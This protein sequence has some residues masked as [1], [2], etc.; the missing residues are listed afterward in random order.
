MASTAEN[1]PGAIRHRAGVTAA[2]GT[3]GSQFA[4]MLAAVFMVAMGYGVI[5]PVLP[6]F[7][8]R[9]QTAPGS[10]SVAW[11][12]GLLTGIYMF[13]LFVFAPLWGRVSDR[14]GRRPVILI[15]FA[16]F[17][18]TMMLFAVADTLWLV[19]PSRA[20]SGVFS[21]AV[22]PVSLAF[23]GDRTGPEQ[24]ARGFALLSA[25]NALGFLAGPML[26]GG[27]ASMNLMVPPIIAA[28]PAGL[29]AV[30]LIAVA[31]LSAWVWVG[32]Y[33]G[34]PEPLA[35]PPRSAGTIAQ[36]AQSQA[37]ANLLLLTLLVMFGLGSFE[38][39]IALHGQQVLN[40]GAT[41]IGF[42]FAEC[43]LVMIAVQAVIF[44]PL[45]KRFNGWSL[46]GPLFLIMAVGLALFPYMEGFYLLTMTVGLVAASSGI[47]IPGLTYLLSSVAGAAQGFALGRQTAASS[48]GQ[49]LGSTATGLL[50]VLSTQSP[51]W[52]ATG[53]LLLAAIVSAHRF[54]GG[55]HPVSTE[56][57]RSSWNG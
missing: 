35:T 32:M 1:E 16:G 17:V 45:V 24:R 42:M 11:H 6:F 39:G 8:E 21:S 53:V 23:V 25:A 55:V 47:L 27:L 28:L 34:F 18:V 5:L 40:L 38:V 3:T 43:S 56:N 10:L 49:A 44:S 51:F 31:V 41:E 50:F 52:L 37:A 20:L 4:L 46:L 15:G 14:I 19:Y 57:R 26:S 7:L 22:L 12:T 30:P 9:L 2:S 54:P 36:A 33:F 48:L 29:Y 13:A